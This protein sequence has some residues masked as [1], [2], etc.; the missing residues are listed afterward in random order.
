MAESSRKPTP[1]KPPT[2]GIG[3][4]A[5]D[6]L[7]ERL[8]VMYADLGQLPLPKRIMDVV[9]KLKQQANDRDDRA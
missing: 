6:Q 2:N 3:H 1:P 9:E 4:R 8:R 5:Q 7:G